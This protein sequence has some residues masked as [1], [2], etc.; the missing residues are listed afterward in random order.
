[1]STC[2]YFYKERYDFNPLY[3]I[4]GEIVDTSRNIVYTVKHVT[5]SGIEF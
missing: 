1:L 4:G 2:L 5:R 3:N